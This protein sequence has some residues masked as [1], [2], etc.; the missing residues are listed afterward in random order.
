MICAVKGPI[1]DH[2]AVQHDNLTTAL[3]VK[4]ADCTLLESKT[5]DFIRVLIACSAASQHALR[6][7]QTF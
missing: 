3:P 6:A 4:W 7:L 1:S 5:I 2:A